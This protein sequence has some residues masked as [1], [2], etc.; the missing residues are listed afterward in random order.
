[1]MPDSYRAI[2]QH[3]DRFFGEED[4][5][6]VFDEKVSPDFHL[7]VYWIQANQKRNYHIL[8]TSGVSS[9]PMN[10]PDPSLNSRIEL[11]I[12]LPPDWP[13]GI[14]QLQDERN[15]WPIGLLK[16]LGRY[17]HS[18][19]TWLG[20]GHTVPEGQGKTIAGTR[21]AA[22]LLKKSK[23]LPPEFQRA[24]FGDSFIDLLMLFPLYDEEY[25]FKRVAGIEGLEA[26][27][28]AANIAD[29]IDVTRSNVCADEGKR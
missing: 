24:E 7:D 14:E 17:P 19:K 6:V 20:F 2:E 26:E 5:I 3:L 12:L 21:F 29:I 23:T 8:L 11:F 16:D 10:V 9:I 25:A 27:F 28:D 15:Y 22:T 1:M 4:T 18:H 13:F